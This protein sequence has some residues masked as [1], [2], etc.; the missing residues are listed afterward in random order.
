M[1]TFTTNVAAG[2]PGDSEP[3]HLFKISPSTV[4]PADS[5]SAFRW[6][7]RAI[8]FGSGE[9]YLGGII[10]KDGI[11][12]MNMGVNLEKGGNTAYISTFRLKIANAQY[13]GDTRFDG[14]VRTNS[15]YFENRIIEHRIIFADKTPLDWANTFVVWT[16]IIEEAYAESYGE[17]LFECVDST[18]AW[19]REIPRTVIEDKNSPNRHKDNVGKVIPITFGDIDHAKGLCTYT[20]LGVQTYRWDTEEVEQ[21]D[22]L[23]AHDA[24]FNTFPKVCATQE[25]GTGSPEYGFSLASAGVSF[26]AATN[27]F[28]EK[29]LLLLWDFFLLD[30]IFGTPI[31]V[32]NPGNVYDG[33]IGTYARFSVHFYTP[34]SDAI[35]RTYGLYTYTG[36]ADARYR[37]AQ[38]HALGEIRRL[39][40]VAKVDMPVGWSDSTTKFFWVQVNPDTPDSF[41]GGGYKGGNSYDNYGKE[42]YPFDA[43]F[44][45]WTTPTLVA[46]LVANVHGSRDSTDGASVRWKRDGWGTIKNGRLILGG[47]WMSNT[48]RDFVVDVYEVKLLVIATLQF[49]K[50][51]HLFCQLKGRVF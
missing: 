50:L 8:D 31:Q 14:Y 10:E 32:A 38:T 15:I 43:D 45:N 3:I 18:W 11:G 34:P 33:D 42:I 47:L 9:N 41:V 24:D 39:C 25:D 19:D 26:N 30:S 21:M 16:G 23:F 4:A 40:L 46:D 7:T 1:R 36:Y 22:Y 20:T 49:S 35:P 2:V 51:P 29:G 27:P 17:F 12:D 5:W 48:N 28:A 13:S 44:D 37:I 6:G